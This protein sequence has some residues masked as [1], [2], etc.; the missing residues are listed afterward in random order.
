MIDAQELRAYYYAEPFQPIEI[1]LADRRHIIV[2]E[3]EHFGWSAESRILM[4]PAGPDVVDAT[5]FANVI[6]IKPLKRGSGRS[7]KA[8]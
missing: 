4:F 5:A 6:E 2:T 7:R 8:S 3:R 1:V